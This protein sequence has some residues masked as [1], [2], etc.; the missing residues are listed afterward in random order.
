M[1]KKE[2]SDKKQVNISFKNDE[3]TLGT[4][5]AVAKAERR[6]LSA[7]IRHILALWCKGRK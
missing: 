7:Q 3:G 5:R 4:V 6:T 1:T 2:M